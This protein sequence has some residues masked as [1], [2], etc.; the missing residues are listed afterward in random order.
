MSVAVLSGLVGGAAVLIL[1]YFGTK[2]AR[3]QGDVQ[4]LEFVDE[5]TKS[6][7]K[8]QHGLIQCLKNLNVRAN[9]LDE[10]IPENRRALIEALSADDNQ[11]I[12]D[13]VE[14]QP[15][16]EELRAQTER[17]AEAAVQLAK[18]TRQA[19]ADRYSEAFA[20]QRLRAAG[21]EE[22]PCL[23]MQEALPQFTATGASKYYRQRSGDMEA[24][25]T[26]CWRRCWRRSIFCPT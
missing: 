17:Y 21:P 22:N 10:I 24:I 3:R 18:L 26:R 8:V 16:F 12:G 19:G 25:S 11:G 4:L 20:E 14:T 13:I 5:R 9:T 7:A 6:V 2:A 23:V 15:Q 1:T